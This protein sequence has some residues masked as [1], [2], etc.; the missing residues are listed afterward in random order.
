MARMITTRRM[1]AQNP[2]LYYIRFVMPSD[3]LAN[4]HRVFPGAAL[5]CCD[6]LIRGK[7]SAAPA[8]LSSRKTALDDPQGRPA[9][10]SSWC[11][12]TELQ[13]CNSGSELS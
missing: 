3:D 11:R 7:R 10:C 1:P 4:R 9:V 6:L 12:P 13:H 5:G 8:E 2:M